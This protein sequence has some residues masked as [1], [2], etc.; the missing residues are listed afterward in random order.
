MYRSVVALPSQLAKTVI[1]ICYLGYF[2]RAP[3]TIGSLV[4]VIFWLIFSHYFYFID[5]RLIAAVMSLVGLILGWISL[6]IYF[7]EKPDATEKNWNDPSWVI[8]DEWAGM[9]IAL[10]S[11]TGAYFLDAALLFFL[12]RVFDIWK[13]GFIGTAQNIPGAIG[14]LLDDVLAGI[15]AGLVYWFFKLILI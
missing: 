14:V 2:T 3:G 12:F 15:L 7:R 10:I 11:V 1:S 6:S 8:I 9:S 5:P 4:T 13:P